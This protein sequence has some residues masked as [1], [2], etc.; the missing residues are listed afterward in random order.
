MSLPCAI[1]GP[2]SALSPGFGAP[3]TPA[4]WHLEQTLPKTVLPSAAAGAAASATAASGAGAAASGAGASGAGAAA[5]GA[6]AAAS[7]AGASGAALS[8]LPPSLHD[9][10]KAA[11]RSAHFCKYHV[12]TLTYASTTYTSL[13]VIPRPSERR[14]KSTFQISNS[15]Y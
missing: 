2:Q 12:K 5:S 13:E 11:S 15:G 14:L 10:S 7:G 6:G 9:G 3:A 8:S 1:R 4:A